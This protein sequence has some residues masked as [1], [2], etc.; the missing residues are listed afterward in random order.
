MRKSISNTLLA[1]S[2]AIV[3]AAPLAAATVSERDA[4]ATAVNKL[5]F[6]GMRLAAR[7]QLDEYLAAGYPDEGRWFEKILTLNFD[8]QFKAAVAA[9]PAKKMEAEAKALRTE[10]EAAVK[11]NTLSPAAVRLFKSGGSGLNRLVN[12]IAHLMHPYQPK[13]LSEYPPEKKDALKRQL[14]ALVRQLDVDFKAAYEPIAAHAAAE[15]VMLG[16]D[17]KDPKYLPLLKESVNLRLDALSIFNAGYTELR[18]A[19]FRG[20]DFGVDPKP[21]AEALKQLLGWMPDGKATLAEKVA[22]WE[23]DFGES[24]PFL[25]AYTAMLLS[26]GVIA[27]VK[28]AKDDDV[29]GSLNAVI[30]FDTKDFKDAKVRAEIYA[31]QF[32]VLA[33]AL[34]WRLEQGKNEGYAKGTEM[35]EGFQ[36]RAKSDPWLKFATTPAELVDELTQAY[37]AAARLYRAK[38]DEGACVALLAEASTAHSGYAGYAKQWMRSGGPESKGGWSKPPLAA[39]PALAV[40]IAKSLFSDASG[41]ADPWLARQSVMKA[42]VQLRD[43]VLGLN[44]GAF[45]SQFVEQAPQVYHYYALAMSKLEW[46]YQAAL[47]SIEGAR[48][49]ADRIDEL[50]RQKKANPWRMPARARASPRAAGRW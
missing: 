16:L 33:H 41:T 42:A 20:A 37:I 9:E 2:L 6:L 23:F 34:R 38:G 3:G 1:L 15:E 4:N 43:A 31:L 50:A 29:D 28:G 49:I 19:A 30:S 14:D 17:E 48:V 12:D 5:S 32:K 35:W 10:L 39:D 27:G 18:E 22:T 8:E 46:R 24:N 21:Y 40:Q 36:A 26:G 44:S 47:V 7:R 25:K 11:S 45:E 13:P